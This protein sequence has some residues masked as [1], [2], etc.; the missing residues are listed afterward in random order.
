[1]KTNE[2]FLMEKNKLQRCMQL[3]RCCLKSSDLR[4]DLCI[5]S[6]VTGIYSNLFTL[7]RP[8]G[9]GRDRANKRILDSVNKIVFEGKTSEDGIKRIEGDQAFWALTCQQLVEENNVLTE[10]NKNL[11][12]GKKKPLESINPLVAE[13]AGLFLN[14][15]DI[16]ETKSSRRFVC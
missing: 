14:N 5:A 10:E 16:E 6:L 3:V 9:L 7:S 12:T 4:K 2:R 15:Q 13:A 1:M 8:G 11:W